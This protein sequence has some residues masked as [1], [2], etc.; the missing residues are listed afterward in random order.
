MKE[1]GMTP[2]VDLL[3]KSKDFWNGYHT[4]PQG[5]WTFHDVNG[6]GK[7]AAYLRLWKCAN[8]QVRKYASKELSSLGELTEHHPDKMAD[9]LRDAD[10]VLVVLR[11]PVSHFLSGYNEFDYRKTVEQELDLPGSWSRWRPGSQERFE[12]FLADLLGGPENI[13][14]KGKYNMWYEIKHV[15]PM[16]SALVQMVNAKVDPGNFVAIMLDE[17]QEFIPKALV[18]SCGIS[19]HSVAEMPRLGQHPSSSDPLRIYAAAKSVWLKKGKAARALCALVAMD[20]ACYDTYFPLP[21][22]CLQVLGR[23]DLLFLPKDYGRE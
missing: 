4:E 12:A 1:L 3:K 16:T 14:W 18:D 19:P 21:E 6:T 23:E 22:V 9:H 7:R 2:D 15:Y 10:C 8:D 13:G 20:Y 17:V 11:D 5:G